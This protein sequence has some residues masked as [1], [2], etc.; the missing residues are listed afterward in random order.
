MLDDFFLGVRRCLFTPGREGIDS[1]KTTLKINFMGFVTGAE[2]TH[3]HLYYGEFPWLPT[4]SY[5]TGKSCPKS[6][7]TVKGR[8]LVSPEGLIVSQD[9]PSCDGRSYLS[10]WRDSEST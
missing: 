4:G 10:V 5:T 6:F 9:N 7:F 2:G 1:Q 8:L 3:S